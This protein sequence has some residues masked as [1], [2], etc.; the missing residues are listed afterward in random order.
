MSLHKKHKNTLTYQTK[1]YGDGQKKENL[2]TFSPQE[3]IE[4][5]SSPLKKPEEKSYIV[6]SQ[7]RSKKL[8]LKD[9]LNL[10]NKNIPTTKSSKISEAESIIKDMDFAP[11]WNHC[12]PV[13][14]RKLWLPPLIA[15]QD[16]TMIYLNGFSHNTEL[17]S[18][19][20]QNEK[21]L[22]QNKNLQKTLCRSLQCSQQEPMEKG[23]IMATRKIRIKPTKTQIAYFNKCFGASRY[24]YNKTLDHLNKIRQDQI[25]DIDKKTTKGCIHMITS[26]KQCKK[27]LLN[28]HFCKD[29]I[30]KKVNI[31][32]G[33][34]FIDLR[35]KIIKTNK[36]LSEDEMWL[37][38]IPFDT[39]QAV[40]RN[41][42][43]NYKSVFSNMK[44]GN[45]NHFKMRFKSKKAS[46][47]VFYIDHRAIKKSGQ[48]IKLF[49]KILKEPLIFPNKKD[50]NWIL[51]NLTNDHN[52]TITLQKPGQYYL[53]I[54]HH[55]ELIENPAKDKMVGIDPGIRTFHTFFSPN[56]Y[57]K[58]GDGLDKHLRR[59]N[60][61]IDKYQSLSCSSKK[62]KKYHLLR[63]ISLLRIKIKNIVRD[64]HWKVSNYYCNNYEYIVI[65]K[66]DIKGIQKSLKK[67]PNSTKKIRRLMNLS[68]GYFM[69]RLKFKALQY[70]NK[71]IIAD[72]SY[73]SKMCGNCGV[74]NNELG[75]SKIFN[76][77][78]CETIIDR[79]INGARNI[80][81]KEICV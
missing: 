73:T 66:L 29:H 24:I 52:F 68:H 51:E 9:K 53:H 38:D 78:N 35:N 40:I 20:C 16:S 81:I 32:L 3:T 48:N 69:E 30:S 34:N 62:Q 45:I 21:I 54:L 5:I 67:S 2:N 28:A 1:L 44:N 59:I 77:S 72:E 23:D 63:K 6:G 50:K 33:L 76:C 8:I 70:N 65:P 18:F 10:C 71:L 49:P 19:L 17:N 75:S 57:G 61:K 25:E 39:R 41:L 14:S 47:Q 27:S 22:P 15:S 64:F 74:L 55:K 79:D 13:V 26:K 7:V 12:F 4:D 43:G 11:F 31:N 58:L 36:T 46:T 56:E 60:L 80:L 37:T 42:I